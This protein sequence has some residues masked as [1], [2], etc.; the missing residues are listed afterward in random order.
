MIDLDTTMMDSNDTSIEQNELMDELEMRKRVAEEDAI[1]LHL[2]KERERTTMNALL[3][4]E[5][6]LRRMNALQEHNKRFEDSTNIL[7]KVLFKDVPI[8]QDIVKKYED[9]LQ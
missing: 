6:L 5:S 8:M 9:T 4:R 1:C 3:E 7:D 2:E